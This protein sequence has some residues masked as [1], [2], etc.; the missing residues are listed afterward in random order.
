MPNSIVRAGKTSL[1]D[2]IFVLDTRKT[3]GGGLTGLL[4]SSS[5]LTWYY[6]RSVATGSTSI[7]LATIT[8]LGTF[9]S[10]GLKE[11]DGTNMP[12]WY[13]V[14]P[15][16]LALATGADGVSFYLGG[17][18]NMAPVY[19]DYQLSGVDVTAV[20]GS[21]VGATVLKAMLESGIACHVNNSQSITT[22][23][24]SITGDSHTL[25]STDDD[26]KGL[27]LYFSGTGTNKP[28]VARK[29]TAYTGSTTLVTLESAL[30]F[31]PANNDTAVI[32]GR[33]G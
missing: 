15:P 29:I 2:K 21:T 12:G 24:F 4:Y 33:S 8:T 20:N 10:G 31:T 9:N 25:S 30:P 5:G 7:T 17:A 19:W 23:S 14:H 16:D 13:E 32:V 26:Y 6:K 3:D 1:V 22:T 27:V 18:A 28:S 11:I